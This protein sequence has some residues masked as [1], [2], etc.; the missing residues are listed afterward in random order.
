[1]TKLAVRLWYGMSTDLGNN[2]Q[3][4][5]A[6]FLPDPNGIVRDHAALPTALH[7]RE[8]ELPDLDQLVR[9]HG[10]LLS[11]SKHHTTTMLEG[12][13][14]F[15]EVMGQPY[16]SLDAVALEAEKLERMG[17]NIV[18]GATAAWFAL[19]HVQT[20]DSFALTLLQCAGY[21]V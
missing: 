12:R 9:L 4:V 17:F 1:M 21:D 18:N 13:L 16:S 5:F 6:I 14:S 20:K 2:G 15:V 3:E 19:A 8:S 7:S 10:R 11:L